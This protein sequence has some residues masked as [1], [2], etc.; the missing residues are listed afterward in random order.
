MYD[1]YCPKPL[2]NS[3]ILMRVKHRVISFLDIYLYSML[4]NI[5][6]W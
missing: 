2:S 1:A 6:L 4:D 3:C 5:K